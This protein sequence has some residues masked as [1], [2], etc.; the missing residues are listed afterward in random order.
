MKKRSVFQLA[1]L[2]VLGLGVLFSLFAF[3]N[4]SFWQRKEQ[5]EISVIIR[6]ADSTGWASARQGMEQAAGDLGA[7]L[8]FLTL[9]RANNAEEQKT[10]LAREVEGGADGVVLVPVNPQQMAENVRQAAGQ[11]AVVTMESDMR[12]NG[13]AAFISV[14]NAAMGQA[15]A[16]QALQQ[17]AAGDVVVLLDS[18]PGGTGVSARVD[19]AEQQLAAAGCTVYRYAA[20]GTQKI[21]DVVKSAVAE[22]APAAVLVFDTP[23]TEQVAAAAEGFANAPL[24]YGTGATSAV[25]AYL[26]Q[27]TLQEI[28]AQNEFAAGY[29]A[30]QAAV[31]AAQKKL[32]GPVPPL[33]FFLVNRQN[34]GE[35]SNQKVLFPVT[36]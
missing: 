2:L 32:D 18:L 9:G 8:R 35:P 12:E 15:L 13:A 10:L 11:T 27:G 30:V 31:Q 17:L 14:D 19:A 5:L 24:L 25:I 21:A 16:G 6:E 33:E 26:E 29:L 4:F 34:M 23:A 3:D 28:A 22:R 1:T 20:D 36:R 7:E